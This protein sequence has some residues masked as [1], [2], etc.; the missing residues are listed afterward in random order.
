MTECATS[1][2][3]KLNH[4]Q[5][6]LFWR[7]FERGRLRCFFPV[8][9][10]LC[11]WGTAPADLHVSTTQFGLPDPPLASGRFDYRVRDSETE[12]GPVA[13]VGC[14]VKS[15]E[16]FSALLGR[17]TGPAVIHHQPDSIAGNFDLDQH[18]PSRT[19]ISAG[20]VHQDGSQ[21]VDPFRRGVD[22]RPS[23]ASVINHKRDP[24]ALG[25]GREAISTC[26]GDGRDVHRLVPGRRAARRQTVRARA[27]PRRWRGAARFHFRPFQALRG[28]RRSSSGRGGRG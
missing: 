16:K 20:V 8:L 3:E 18:G 9:R 23:I 22:P 15:V 13:F 26:C 1:C 25:Y 6:C 27:D 7:A 24:F 19:G 2:I 11:S 14:P 5:A 17:D 28:S 21:T 10:P 4:R 12:A